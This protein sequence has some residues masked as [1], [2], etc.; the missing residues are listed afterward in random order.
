MKSRY[1]LEEAKKTFLRE[2]NKRDPQWR[3]KLRARK[4]EEI[5]RMELAKERIARELAER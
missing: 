4:L 3:E 5:K 2:L 1:Q